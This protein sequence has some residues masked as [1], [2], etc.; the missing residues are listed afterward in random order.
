MSRDDLKHSARRARPTEER[1]VRLPVSTVIRGLS[2]V[3]E[4]AFDSFDEVVTA[5]IEALTDVLTPEG[6][7]LHSTESSAAGALSPHFAHQAAGYIAKIGPPDLD[8]IPV[9]AAAPQPRNLL[10]SKIL[11][12]T[13]SRFFPLK[14]VTRELSAEI[15][16]EGGRAVDLEAFRRVIGPRAL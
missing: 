10:A 1:V 5:G 11:L 15:Q 9:E 2:L 7:A 8:E 4:G 3:Q 13:V 14:I 6:S 16:R 12:F